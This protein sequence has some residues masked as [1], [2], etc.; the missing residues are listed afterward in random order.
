MIRRMLL[1]IGLSMMFCASAS[2]VT[3]TFVGSLDGSQENGPVATTGTGF[4]TAVFDSVANTLAVDLSF[5][6]LLNPTNNAHIHCCATLAT[7]AGAAIDFPSV[8]FPI[9]VT[10]GS[11]MHTFDLG[12]TGTYT[13]A[14][15]TASGGTAAGARNRLLDSMR[16]LT[17]GNLGIAYFNIH[18]TVNPAGEIRGNI[19]PVP[20]PSSLGLI[21]LGATCFIARRRER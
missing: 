21:A 12:L 11:F 9:G 20:E 19:A 10:S 8:G 2:A 14:Y 4:G 18:T 3:E 5:A 15:L 13:N 7:N 17:G 6:N 1:A 16:R